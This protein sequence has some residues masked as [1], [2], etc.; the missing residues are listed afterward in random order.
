[1]ARQ[2]RTSAEQSRRFE[3]VAKVS[4]INKRLGIVFGWAAESLRKGEQYFDTQGDHYTEDAMV[5]D[6][7]DFMLKSRTSGEM[8]EVVDG[9][10]VFLF[11]L[12]S[13]LAKAFEIKTDRTGVM[14]GI[15]P[16]PEVLAKFESGEY[17]GFSIGGERLDE[18]VVEW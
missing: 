3:R 2:N 12:T 14:V 18:E 6:F 10:V 16:S 17:T 7:A 1:M 5:A 13:D 4:T 8:H 15:K 11:P 9:D